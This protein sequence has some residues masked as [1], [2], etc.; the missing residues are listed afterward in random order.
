MRRVFPIV[1]FAI[2]VAAVFAM[3][4]ASV[5]EMGKRAVVVELFTSQGCSSCPPADELLRRMAR[6]PKLQGRV[7][8]LAF[9]VD[10]WNSLGWR[11]PFSSHAWSE[12]QGDYVRAL[13]LA[14]AYTPQIVVD[15]ARQMVGS[16][17]AQVYSAIEEESRRP[18]DAT[19]TLTKVAGGYVVNASSPRPDAD[20][21]FVTF[22][23]DAS[24]RV[25]AGENSGRTLAD[26]AIVRTLAHVTNG[27]KVDVD[28]K[29]GVAAFLQ[30]RK[31]KRI[32]AATRG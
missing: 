13:R 20:L 6:D 26:D 7:I 32:L 1:L 12:R 31:T 25:T 4:R 21:I 5:P 24:T 27:A 16:N 19:V 11:D 15:G 8:P 9:H 17:A 22:E 18:S 10:Y 28:A 29:Y 3:E 14:S 30:D 2:V 23:N